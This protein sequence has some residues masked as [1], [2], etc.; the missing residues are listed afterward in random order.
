MDYGAL[1]WAF[2]GEFTTQVGGLLPDLLMMQFTSNERTRD[3][4]SY[5]DVNLNFKAPTLYAQ[6]EGS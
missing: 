1:I 6:S 5:V 4:A 2:Q 3:D